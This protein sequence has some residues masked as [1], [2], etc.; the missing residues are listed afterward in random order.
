M[1]FF[2]SLASP[3]GPLSPWIKAQQNQNEQSCASS[4]QPELYYKPL[5]REWFDSQ[6]WSFQLQTFVW[7]SV[8]V[9]F[10]RSYMHPSLFGRQFLKLIYWLEDC[11]PQFM[12]RF[13][14]YPVFVMN[15]PALKM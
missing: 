11:C 14:Q 4:P 8:S 5:D 12:G 2:E 15:K 1:G 10:L 3:T 6:N 9:S 13:G 7:R